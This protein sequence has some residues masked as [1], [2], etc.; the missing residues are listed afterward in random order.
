M[1]HKE[2]SNSFLE[3]QEMFPICEIEFEQLEENLS[4]IFTISINAIPYHEYIGDLEKLTIFIID[5]IDTEFI[6]NP[7]KAKV[8]IDHYSEFVEKLIETLE[9]SKTTNQ[10]VE[11][12]TIIKLDLKKE[13]PFSYEYSKILPSEVNNIEYSNINKAAREII[14]QIYNILHSLEFEFRKFSLKVIK[15]TSGKKRNTIP[16]KY[17]TWIGPPFKLDNLYDDLRNEKIIECNKDMFLKAF[18]GKMF[19]SQLDIIWKFEGSKNRQVIS[20][21]SIFRFIDLLQKKNYIVQILN[22][23]KSLKKSYNTNCYNLIHHIFVKPNGS[24]FKNLRQSWY[25]YDILTPKDHFAKLDRLI[26]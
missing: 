1:A 26:K 21:T 13:F 9:W 23:D 2:F 25:G 12:N 11:W 7:D 6:A 16:E 22:T 24:R 14:S 17:F 4:S 5:E 18:S 3:F 19:E 8:L 20:H 15:S 10:N